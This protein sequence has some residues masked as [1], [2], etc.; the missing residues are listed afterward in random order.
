M[1]KIISHRPLPITA[2]TI[3]AVMITKPDG[4]IINYYL[5]AAASGPVTLEIF[6]DKEKLVR[7]YAG[8]GQGQLEGG[9]ANV[10][11]GAHERR[12]GR[13]SIE[14]LCKFLGLSPDRRSELHPAH[15][16]AD[17]GACGAR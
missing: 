4:A 14:K 9:A 7:R 3:P 8:D 13:R 2:V 10:L 15:G 6:D 11:D 1:P 5:R 17:R 12:L 16:P